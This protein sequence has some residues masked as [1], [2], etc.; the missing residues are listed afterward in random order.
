M[1]FSYGIVLAATLFCAPVVADEYVIH[2]RNVIVS[3]AQADAEQMARTGV[4]RHC[5]RNAG[6]RE[7]I[8]FSTRSADEAVRNCCFYG[9]Y[10]VVERGVARGPKGWF[11][12]LRYAD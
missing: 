4:L 2:A 11:A 6:Q 7:G 12:V 10:R 1:R 5:G 8:G 3:S 9:R